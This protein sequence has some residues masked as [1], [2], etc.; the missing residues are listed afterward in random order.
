M[1]FFGFLI[2][3]SPRLGVAQSVSGA[4]Y[5][6]EGGIV[7]QAGDLSGS[8]YSLSGSS[9]AVVGSTV[10]GTFSQNQGEF[11]GGA[12][13]PGGVIPV[14]ST[15]N[16]S[17]VGY[18]ISAGGGNLV[19][20]AYS[21]Y[22]KDLTLIITFSNPRDAGS[23]VLVGQADLSPFNLTAIKQNTFLVRFNNVA[24][25]VYTLGLGKPA[26]TVGA[27]LALYSISV[28]Q[29]GNGVVGGPDSVIDT[30]GQVRVSENPVQNTGTTSGVQNNTS[31]KPSETRAVDIN[32]VATTATTIKSGTVCHLFGI[33]CAYLPPIYIL[34]VCIIGYLM[35]KFVISREKA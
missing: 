29:E 28:N 22:K 35:H 27:P 12:S 31:V 20:D 14:S 17:G 26:H 11:G 32:P 7:Y 3:S 13:A 24:Q 4:V 9:D 8:T 6:L 15:G 2:L 1:L 21:Y 25:G 16:S 33:K 19:I 23:I 30:G 18:S 34:I 5:S 10:G